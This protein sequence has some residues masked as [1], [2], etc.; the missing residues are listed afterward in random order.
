MAENAESRCG[1]KWLV[2]EQRVDLTALSA[3][4]HIRAVRVPTESRAVVSGLSFNRVIG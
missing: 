3:V 1:S 2:S 4:G